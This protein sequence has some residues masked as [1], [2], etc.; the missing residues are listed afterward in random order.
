MKN[1]S[2]LLAFLMFV[3]FG[4]GGVRDVCDC[5]VPDNYSPTVRL[6]KD[7]ERSFHIQ[8]HDTLL[9]ERIVLVRFVYTNI[10]WVREG[11]RTPTLVLHYFRPEE[12]RSGHMY[13]YDRDFMDKQQVTVEILPATDRY[14]LKLPY[15][16]GYEL[17]SAGDHRFGNVQVLVEHPFK[18]Y[19]V[20]TPSKLIFSRTEKSQ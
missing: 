20:G 7:T 12:F 14:K 10:N 5:G 9:E 11:W 1:I 15:P 13:V 4:C 17:S 16:L 18:P 3:G 19:K 6:V 8:W 2:C